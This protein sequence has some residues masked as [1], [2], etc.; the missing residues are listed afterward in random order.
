MTLRSSNHALMLNGGGEEVMGRSTVE[1]WEPLGLN[2]VLL[3]YHRIG[4]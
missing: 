3:P 1:N 2:C 4:C